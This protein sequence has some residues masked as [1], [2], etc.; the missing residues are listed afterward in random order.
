MFIHRRWW[1]LTFAQI[2]FRLNKVRC[3]NGTDQNKTRVWDC[4]H[5]S[6]WCH[7][8]TDLGVWFESFWHSR[9]K[10]TY[11]FEPRLSVWYLKIAIEYPQKLKRRSRIFGRAICM[12]GRR[13]INKPIDFIWG[14]NC[15]QNSRKDWQKWQPCLWRSQMNRNMWAMM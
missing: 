9:I 11:H 13:C 6:M 1:S 4:A 10:I 12:D 3:M 14:E 8:P 2:G 7:L 5:V 15:F